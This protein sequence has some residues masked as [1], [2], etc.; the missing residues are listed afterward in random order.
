MFFFF[1]YKSCIIFS[2]LLDQFITIFFSG[3]D[4]RR[5]A[6][7]ASTKSCINNIF[8]LT[9]IDLSGKHFIVN[10]KNESKDSNNHAD[11][12]LGRRRYLKGK[13]NSQIYH[14]VG[15]LS[16]TGNICPQNIIVCI[17]DLKLK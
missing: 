8:H 13:S 12:L 5:E 16:E 2:E 14:G 17:L 7:Q 11:I 1:E 10:R 15:N 4:K 3:S 6:R 9:S